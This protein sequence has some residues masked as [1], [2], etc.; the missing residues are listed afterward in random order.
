LLIFKPTPPLH[1]LTCAQTKILAT[2][3]GWLV[4]AQ[5]FGFQF[6]EPIF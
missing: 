6:F 3:V 2:V 4:A 5:A 1:T